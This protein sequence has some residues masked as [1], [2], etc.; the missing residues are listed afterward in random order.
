MGLAFKKCEH[1]GKVIDIKEFFEVK[2]PFYLD[3]YMPIC[4]GCLVKILEKLDWENWVLIDKLCQLIDVPFIPEKWVEVSKKFGAKGIISY[5]K[6][7]QE[8]MYKSLDWGKMQEKYKQLQSEK[9]LEEE[10]IPGLK[11]KIKKDLQ[12]KWGANYSL[13]QLTYL[14]HLYNGILNTQNVNGTLQIDQALKLCK[15]SLS[16]DDAIRSGDNID[17]LLGSYEKLIKTAEFTPKNVKNAKDFDSV[18][19]LFAYLEKTGYVNKFY[20]DVSRDIVDTTMKNI[21]QF[22]QRLYTQEPGIGEDIDKRI[23]G[24]KTAKSIEDSLELVD[25]IDGG[26]ELENEDYFGEDLEEFNPEVN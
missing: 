12:D 23:E 9:E 22:C 21:Q 4:N 26:I 17:K 6:I 16:I 8:G 10:V 7:V 18:G 11:E 1:C 2:N 3:G 19:E 14:E 24:L 25:E 5:I 13:E 20:D 15:L